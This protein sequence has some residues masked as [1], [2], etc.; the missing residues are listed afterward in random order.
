MVGWWG[1]G[2]Q[3]VSNNPSSVA[4][5]WTDRGPALAATRLDL[6]GHGLLVQL[7]A[8]AVALLVRNAFVVEEN[9]LHQETGCLVDI[10]VILGKYENCKK[11]LLAEKGL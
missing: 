2:S 10:Y 4:G 11:K 5:E 7:D 8:V 3:S 6:G 1:S 9:V